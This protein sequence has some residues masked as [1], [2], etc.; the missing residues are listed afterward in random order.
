MTKRIQY[1]F[2]RNRF[3]QA[4]SG[5]PGTIALVWAVGISIIGF[6]AGT[7][8]P[9]AA[10]T[11]DDHAATK[12]SRVIDSADIAPAD[13]NSQLSAGSKAAAQGH[14]DEAIAIW[15]PLADGG[16]AAA[17]YGLGLIY[18][19][20]RSQNN[21]DHQKRAFNLFEQAGSQGHVR[22]LF[23]LGV[24]H[25]RGLGTEKDMEK[26]LFFYR[27]AAVARNV[28]A[29]VNLA[30]LLARGASDSTESKPR[31]IGEAYQW[32]KIAEQQIK[33]T[34]TSAALSARIRN[35]VTLLA[36]KTSYAE[37]QKAHKAARK[38]LGQPV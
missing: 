7:A 6:L 26:A 24:G 12:I 29:Q 36:A 17:Q 21:G 13:V 31:N 38:I 4:I 3:F 8:L 1:Y 15:T 23:Q 20:A 34:P 16:V 10:A 37:R 5:R 28:G 14:F 25:E 22:S 30:I 32:A 19:Q 2:Q 35:M 27:L 9:A 11:P 18:R 33:R